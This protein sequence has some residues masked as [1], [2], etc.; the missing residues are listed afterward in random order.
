[1]DG[2]TSPDGRC[3]PFDADANGTVW[4]SGVGVVLLKRLSDAIADGDHVR[5][6]V[7]GNAINNDGAGKVGFTA[8]SVDGQVA[9]IAQAL[10]DGRR[11]PAHHQLRRGAR[12]RHGAGRPDRG[13]RACR[14]STAQDTD[15]RGW[16]GIGSVKSQHR[17]PQPAAGIV[18]VIKT[19]LA[20][21]HGLIPPTINFETPNPAIDFADTPFYVA[22]DA[23]QV[24]RR[25]RAA[26]GR[27][28]LV[29]HR[30]HQ[31]ARGARG[32]AGGVP[33]RPAGRARRTCSRSA[34]PT[35]TAAGRRGASA[36]PTTWRRG[37]RRTGDLGRRRA[38]PAGRPAGSTAH[39]RAVVATDLRRR[40]R[41][42]ASTRKR[43]REPV[44]RRRRPGWRFLFSG[45]GAQYAGMGAQL[46]AERAGLRGRR[47]R[48]R[49]AAP[50]R[51][52]PGPARADPRPRPGRPASG[53][54]R[55]RCTQPALFTVEYALA[56]LWQVA[57]VA[58][59]RDDRPLHRRVRRRHRRRG[60]EPAGRA[61]GGRRP[62]PADAVGCRRVRCWPSRCDEAEVAARLP[63][64]LAVATVNGPGTCV[65][66]GP[67]RRRSRRSPPTLDGRQRA[68]RCA[69][70]TRSTRR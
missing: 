22:N 36:W 40:G 42:A 54:S 2:F 33:G 55:P 39:R 65:V 7:L 48:V 29:R 37:R 56:V 1:M 3:R 59:G 35:P 19:V 66:A 47:R 9:V 31:R 15:E 12:H 6:V 28:Q 50:P 53:S 51:A 57:G 32:G 43:G 18:G 11:R 13:R 69:P 41:R 61:A 14:A 38:H 24:G 60:A 45:Q 20:M 27:G 23:D 64:G 8:P 52:G 5:A 26:A 10:G 62:G 44:G 63:A 70:R 67:S 68:S 30:R 4:G 21:E 16:C 49:R 46:Y 17:P 34:R 58:A 25:R